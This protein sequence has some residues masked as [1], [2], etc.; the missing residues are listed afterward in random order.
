M[1][2]L[3]K[4]RHVTFGLAAVMLTFAGAFG[5]FTYFRPFL[6]TCTRV[7]VPQLSLL[8]LGQGIAGFAG[9]YGA[10]ALLERHLYR[11][12]AALPIALGLVTLALLG[13]GHKLWAVALT[14]VAWGA[15][16]SAIPVA[17]AAWL[18]KAIAD[19][20][21][22]GGGLLVGAIQLAIMLGA[23]FGGFLLDYVSIG[24]ALIGGAVLLVLASLV[25][26]DG[27]RVQARGVS[28]NPLSFPQIGR[29]Q[30][31]TPIAVCKL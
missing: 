24:A 21:E 28:K 18:S 8:L 17:W 26:G 25:V 6:E 5:A 7:S 11:L 12:M 10:G 30:P 3:L 16:N 29:S 13:G 9:T 2:C 23:A 31:K 19:E 15:L 27:S 20:P 22:R 14:L 1:A 4:R